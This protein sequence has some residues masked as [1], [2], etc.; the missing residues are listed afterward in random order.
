MEPRPTPGQVS[1]GI[2]P[3]GWANDDLRDW[4]AGTP[5]GRILDEIAA[6]GYAG[7]E[8]SYTFPREPAG[9]RAELGRRGLTLAAAYRWVNFTAPQQAESQ[10]AAARAH[11][12]FCAAAGARA[13]VIAEAGGSLHWDAAG[14]RATVKTLDARGWGLLV[15]GL[16]TLGRYARERGIRLCVHPHGGTAIEGEPEI[17]RLMAETD[18]ELVWLCPDSG[19]IVYGGGDPAAVVRRHAR[20]VGHVHLKDVRPT[21]L[22]R[23]RAGGAPFFEALRADV[24]CTPGAGCI[25]FA[26]LLSALAD[27]D[28]SGWLVVEADQNPVAHPPLQVASAARAFLR[29]VAGV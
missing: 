21:S 6:A 17:D 8:M 12:D 29:E 9:L 27:A 1:V 3:I 20:R 15:E 10:L 24:F 14:S 2:G 5:A 22:R 26:P 18:P 23:A 13:A 4:G 11:V 16:H 25:D 7:T 28:Y 19:H